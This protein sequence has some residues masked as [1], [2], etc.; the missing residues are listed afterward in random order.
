MNPLQ[1]SQS[2]IRALK[3]PSDPP[4]PGS[5][6]KVEIARQAWENAAPYI[7]CKGEI[8]AEWVLSRFLKERDYDLYDIFPPFSFFS[9]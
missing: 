4:H 5:P 9:L 3:S 8:I 6:S 2:F 7:P 1:S